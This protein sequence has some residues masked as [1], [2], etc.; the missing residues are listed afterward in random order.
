MK[1]KFSKCILNKFIDVLYVPRKKVY[2]VSYRITFHLSVIRTAFEV[3]LHRGV[4]IS[5]DAL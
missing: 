2:E 4:Q 3:G 5:E 1:P